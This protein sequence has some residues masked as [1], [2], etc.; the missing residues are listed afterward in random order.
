MQ[1]LNCLIVEDEPL[2]AE[3]LASYIK[4]AG[5]LEIAA[6]CSDA[7]AAAAELRIKQIDL[8]F[9][10][11]H[12][13]AIKGNVFL[14][15][16]KAPRPRVIITSAYE[17]YAL[18]GF[19][20]EV[21][22]YLLKPFSF[23][24]FLKAVNRIKPELEAQNEE[25]LFRFFNV[26]KKQVKVWLDDIIYIESLKDYVKIHTQQ[27]TLVTKFQIG[28]LESFIDDKR[29]VRVHRSYL[30]AKNKITAVTALD[31]EVA[32]RLIPI[33]RSFLS[34]VRAQLGLLR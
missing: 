31:V 13:P 6:V 21:T 15:T 16:M 28:Q 3:V 32:G 8:I 1:K 30:V 11:I 29:F 27:G 17:Q 2:A 14:K 24:R 5:F 10:D 23:E 33:G 19:E 9:L 12:L 26:N 34:M 20:M 25:H 18:E 7:V 22:D 4:Q